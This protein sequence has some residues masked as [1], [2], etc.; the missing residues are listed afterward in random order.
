MHGEVVTIVSGLPRSGTSMMM[1]M[2]EAGG[3]PVLTDNVRQ[4]DDDNPK[5]YYEFE[6]VK[7]IQHDASWLP[8]AA[9]RVVKMISALLRH[10]PPEYSYRI[11]FMQRDMNEILASQRQMLVRRREPTTDDD[12]KMAALFEKHL[13]EVDAWI[14]QQPHIRILYVSYNDILGSPAQQAALVNDFLG[15]GLNVHAMVD[16]VDHALHRQRG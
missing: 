13:R 16:V 4:A 9:G 5:G 14:R 15:G 3:L 2:L 7:A 8:D 10:L 6:R 11:I 1:R 12:S